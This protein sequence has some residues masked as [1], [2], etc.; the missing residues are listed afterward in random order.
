VIRVCFL[1][2]H[3]PDSG[4]TSRSGRVTPPQGHEVTTRPLSRP[5]PRIG[6]RVLTVLAGAMLAV[7]AGASPAWAHNTLTSTNP[8]DQEMVQSTPPAVILTF[9][10]PV[11]AT[12]TQVVVTGPSGQ[13]QQ[14][15][16]RLAEN[17]VTQDLQ[18]G[19][20]AGAYTV[21]WRVTSADGH[22]VSGTFFFT[23]NPAATQPPTSQTSPPATP[24]QT[25][26]TRMPGWLKLVIGV[27][28]IIFGI[29]VA[30]RASRRGNASRPD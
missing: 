3:R 24:N 22:P 1:G 30:R 29:T 12:G 6:S 16:P 19:A 21:A 26:P 5:A 14:G 11:I 25:E 28:A 4:A 23:A 17:T 2:G 13:I 18:P 20:P 15:R 10:E 27:V 8:A 7:W 9:N